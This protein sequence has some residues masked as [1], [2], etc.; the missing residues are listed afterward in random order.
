[1]IVL[2]IGSVVAGEWVER[3]SSV[4]Q[5][6]P[7][8]T[9]TVADALAGIT[10]LATGIVAVDR[11]RR[12]ALIAFIAGL[13][14]FAGNVGGL[15][16]WVH[17][18]LMAH[19]ALAY[20]DGRLPRPWVRAVIALW[21]ITAGLPSL[22]RS[23]AVAIILGVGTAAA[24]WIAVPQAALG[25]RHARRTGAASAT[26]IGAALALTA[27]DRL[28][29]FGG[30]LM[31]LPSVL[32]A[33]LVTLAGL[34]LLVGL[35][36]PGGEADAVIEVGEERPE[37]LMDALRREATASTTDPATREL[38]TAAVARFDENRLL[39]ADLE[40]RVTEVRASRRRLVEAGIAERERLERRLSEGAQGYLDELREVVASLRR[41]A[42]VKDLVDTCLTEIENTSTD[43][44]QLA[45]GLHPVVLTERGLRPALT[46]LA[47]RSPIP[48]TVRAPS[49]RLPPLV[50]AT[51]W[52]GCAE[53][54][55]NMIKYSDASSAR[56]D[57]DVEGPYVVATVTDDGIGGASIATG[58]GLAGIADR[59]NAVDGSLAVDSPPGGGTRLIIRVPVR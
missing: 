52:Y 9:I 42:A 14:W 32:Y 30:R 17:R 39:H 38:L 46:D 19:A 53:A 33:G 34:I 2:G 43:L 40:Q 4:L 15:L 41:D 23:P 1:M 56:I 12:F 11:S 37:L 59:M 13:S 24:S 49:T 18:P 48:T 55:A 58:G 28:T 5:H 3:S 45:Q 20:P 50:E 27:L 10:F 54:M 16:A 8:L 51:V 57:V 35:L 7:W 22:A 31:V 29:T 44:A 26:A 25:R 6:A 47:E 21:W 36:Q